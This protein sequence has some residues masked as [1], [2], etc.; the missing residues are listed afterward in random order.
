V[1]AN[2]RNGEGRPGLRILE[3]WRFEHELD[4]R[5]RDCDPLGH[6]NNAVYLSYLEAA[7]FSWWRHTFGAAGFTTH[8]FIIARVEIDYRKPAL[9]GDRLIV[10]LRVDAIGTSSFHLVYEIANTRTREVIAEAR[11]V[12]VAYDYAQGRSVSLSTDLRAKLETGL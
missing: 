9:P 3:M 5:F 11:S 2:P 10:R 8:G 1:P 4:V 12:Q 7:R 6:V